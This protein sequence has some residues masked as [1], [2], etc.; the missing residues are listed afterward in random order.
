L[1]SIER[2][3]DRAIDPTIHSRSID[4]S[5]LEST[6]VVV[7]GAAGVL[8]EGQRGERGEVV[9]RIMGRHH[10]LVLLLLANAAL[11][12]VM[13]Q[14]WRLPVPPQVSR[15]ISSSP[16]CS[17]RSI[18]IDRSINQSRHLRFVQKQTLKRFAGATAAAAAPPPSTP[19]DRCSC[20]NVQQHQLAW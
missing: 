5:A 16:V 4:R 9:A 3:R 6:Q 7:G 10:G 1:Y 13:V 12:G 2:L 18:E 14:G 17:V 15:S 11:L 8:T 20:W 19:D